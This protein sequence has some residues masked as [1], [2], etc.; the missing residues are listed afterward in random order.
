M[1]SSSSSSSRAAKSIL[2]S[3]HASSSASSLGR[4]PVPR[5]AARPHLA[6]DGQRRSY[7]SSPSSSKQP[8]KKPTVDP[9]AR[10]RSQYNTDPFSLKPSEEHYHLPLVTA[11][12][13]AAKKTR[14]RGVRMLARDFIHDSLYNPHYGYFSR[15]AVLLP[16][17][18]RERVIKEDNEDLSHSAPNTTWDFAAFANDADFMTAVEKRYL[19]FEENLLKSSSGSSSKASEATSTAAKLRKPAAAPLAHSAAGLDAAKA[20]GRIANAKSTQEGAEHDEDVTSMVARQVWHTPTELFKPHYANI[21]AQHCIDER[22]SSDVPLVIY[23]LGAGSGALAQSVLNYVEEHHP[24]I[25]ATMSYN[26]VE[27]S[28][29]LATQQSRRLENHIQAGKVQVHR[30]DFMQWDRD[31]SEECT[32]IALEVLDNLSHDVIRYS[33]STLQPY[34]SYVSIDS[35]GDMHELFAP[36]T[37]PLIAEYLSLYSKLRPN[38]PAPSSPSYTSLIPNV[39]RA[40]LANN[41]PLYPNLTPPHY[42]PTTSLSLLKT[43]SKHFTNHRFLTSDFHSLPEAIQGLNGPVVQTRIKGKMVPVG[44]Y[45]VLQ[46]YFD[47]FFPTDFEL[48]KDMYRSIVVVNDEK[49]TNLFSHAGF[50]ER[51]EELS[52]GCELKD[53]SNPM[54]TWYQNASWLVAGGKGK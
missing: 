16:D 4:Q 7:A 21:I 35:T 49:K 26:I 3:A 18:K 50:L 48:L 46:G 25:Y 53:G 5:A 19:D 54:L 24:D 33:T 17:S 27:I 12:D 39:L 40:P 30:K 51:Y 2:R 36:I 29:R 14:P 44:K 37:D 10:H 20:Q 28:D 41:F 1:A 52:K 32:V 11:A 9:E 38:Q 8:P 47:I 43:L 15:H 34:Q 23:E 42:I 6:L 22:S 13:L 45:T 31:V